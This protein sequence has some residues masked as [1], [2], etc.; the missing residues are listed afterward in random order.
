[1]RRPL[2]VIEKERNIRITVVPSPDGK[3]LDSEQLERA[4]YRKRPWSI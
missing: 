3:A 4:M 2:K 1:M